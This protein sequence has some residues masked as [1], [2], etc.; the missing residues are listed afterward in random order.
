MRIGGGGV[1]GGGG[2]GEEEEEG[3]TGTLAS[4]I[5]IPNLLTNYPTKLH[6]IK[7]MCTNIT[8]EHICL[9]VMYVHEYYSRTYLSNCHVCTRVLLPNIFV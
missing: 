8:P 7:T 9:I 5:H 3:R 1:R 4:G 6:E 2:G